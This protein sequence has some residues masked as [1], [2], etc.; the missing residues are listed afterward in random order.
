[1]KYVQERKSGERKSKVQGNA[2]MLTLF[3]ERP[4]VFTDQMIVDELRDFFGAAMMTT[5]YAS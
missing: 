5:Q 1:M 3:L 2:D 4:D